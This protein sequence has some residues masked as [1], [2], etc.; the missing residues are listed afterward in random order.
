M[1]ST[2]ETGRRTASGR[3][4]Q[5]TQRSQTTQRRKTAAR[6]AS[7][8][9]RTERSQSG[10]TPA[11]RMHTAHTDVPIPYFTPGD[12]TANAHVI[13]SHLPP[14]PPPRQLAFYGGLGA[15]ALAGAVDWP[16]ALAIGAATVVARGKGR[17]DGAQ[18]A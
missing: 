11:V 9:R 8:A 7:T 12:L 16:V 10:G 17:G 3:S 18:R 2:A 1:S 13:T 14:L 5:T 6:K 4:A 15:L